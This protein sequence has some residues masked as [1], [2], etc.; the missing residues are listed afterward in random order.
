MNW[1]L[2]L[3]P[4]TRA[5]GGN[6]DPATLAS[7]F[8]LATDEI[9]L[10]YPLPAAFTTQQPVTYRGTVVLS[11]KP[12]VSLTQQI[13]RYLTEYPGDEA[14]TELTNART[15]LAGRKVLSQ[16][17]DTFSPA[18]TLRTSIPQIPVANLVSSPDLVTRAISAAASPATGENWYNTGFNAL[19]PISTGTQAQYNYGPL[20][21]GFAQILSLTIVDVFGQVMSL[22]TATTPTPGTLAV[23]TS[24]A[25]SPVAG[26]TANAGKAY[27]PPRVLA[28]ARV[29]A[30]WLRPL[31]PDRPRVSDDFA[32]VNDHPATSPVCGWIVPNHLDVSLAFYDA[33]GSPVGSFGIEHGAK[34]YRSWPGS[35]A[36]RATIWTRHRH[37][38]GAAGERPRRAPDAVRRPPATRLPHRPDGRHGSSDQFINPAGSPRTPRCRC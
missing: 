24:A 27:L 5:S 3:D 28:P 25:L 30:H 1:E 33:D 10:S 8:I 14:D 20:R 6:Y 11:K 35:T 16:A 34:K 17:L 15:D 26:D 12:F 4:L 2:S 37:G 22:A 31:R 19:T 18:Q 38:R 13:D 36:V 7:R 29:D 9:D 21:A 23:T 32:E